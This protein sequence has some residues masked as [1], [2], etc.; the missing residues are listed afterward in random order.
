M[1]TPTAKSLEVAPLIYSPSD[2]VTAPVL[3]IPGVGRPEDYAGLDVKGKIVMVARG[4]MY[5]RDKTR[6]AARAG[7]AAVLIYSADSPGYVGTLQERA[8]IPALVIST[9]DARELLELIQQAP[10]TLRLD[11]ETE[12]GLTDG[13]NIIA[14]RSGT[15]GDIIVFGAHYDSVHSSPGADD[16]GSGVAVVLELA[17]ALA[18]A[19]RPET[20]VFIAFDAEEQ[21]LIGSQRY[22]SQL[23]HDERRRI[24]VMFDFDELGTSDN[25][26]D[27]SGTTDWVNRAVAVGQRLGA[28]P[29][30]N[31]IS[32]SDHDSFLRAGIPALFFYREDPLFHTPQDTADRVRAESLESAGRIALELID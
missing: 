31:N 21:G 32:G 2:H 26:L 8:E 22:V 10:V 17:R 16:N 5:L 4:Q 24:K 7:A 19:N 28:N 20:L 6:N 11:S 29:R 23:S 25:R 3:C 13:I 30:A 27:I 9:E 1:L 15:S 18:Q 14:T 12:I